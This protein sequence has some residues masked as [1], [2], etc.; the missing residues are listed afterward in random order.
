M[1]F[2][3]PL[4]VFMIAVFFAPMLLIVGTSLVSGET[5]AF[6]LEYYQ[7]FF[8]GGLYLRVLYNS[9]EIAV[10]ST[11]LT[12]AIGYPLAY[13]LAKQTPRMRVYLSML[14]LLPFYTSILVKSF[15]FQIILGREGIVN[16]IGT[17]IFGPVAQLALLYNRTGVYFGIVHDMLPFLV[18]PIVVSLLAQDP[19]LYRAAELMGA[20]RTRIFW[21]ITF[22]LSMPG[23]LAGVFLVVV[24]AMGQYAVPQ[25]LG[26]RQDMMMANLVGFHINEILDWNMASAISMVLLAV[27]A[28]FLFAL[29]R[30]RAGD[31][32]ART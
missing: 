11:I 31:T 4:L 6:T 30:V 2:I 25:L 23:V 3:L 29:G 13:F 10:V 9:L 26:G 22:P 19:A 7:R 17:S 28:V 18:F 8:T 21:R 15:A 27:S 14:L 20:G 12:L 32:L 5:G 24:R 1:P 16:W